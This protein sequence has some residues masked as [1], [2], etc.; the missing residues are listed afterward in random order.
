MHYNELIDVLRK[1]AETSTDQA[2][3][4]L[5]LAAIPDGPSV[6]RNCG[7]Q[8]P[9][10]NMA[11]CSHECRRIHQWGIP[12]DIGERIDAMRKDGKTFKEIGTALGITVHQARQHC[13]HHG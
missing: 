11:Y 9:K 8:T 7:K 4:E 5:A 1:I 10:K 2:S 3:R 6:C 13:P 12:G